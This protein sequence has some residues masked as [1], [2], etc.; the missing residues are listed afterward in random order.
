MSQVGIQDAAL[1]DLLLA[2][3]QRQNNTL[4]RS[5]IVLRTHNLTSWN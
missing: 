5:G 1:A 3:K 4:G 2:S